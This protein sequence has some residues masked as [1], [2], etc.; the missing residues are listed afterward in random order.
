MAMNDKNHYQ[1]RDWQEVTNRPFTYDR[2]FYTDFQVFN[3]SRSYERDRMRSARAFRANDD[4]DEHSSD[5]YNNE[6]G[7]LP[8]G[9][10]YEGLVGEPKPTGDEHA[11]RGSAS[12]KK[13]DA[14]IY[15]DINDNL[16]IGR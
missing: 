11:G 13:A 2:D 14:R 6:D 12:N 16:Q 4:T 15:D 9:R 5:D 7:Y 1:I 8:S 10:S 3:F